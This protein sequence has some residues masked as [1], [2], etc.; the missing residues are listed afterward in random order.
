MKTEQGKTESV[1][2]T[3]QPKPAKLIKKEKT[4]RENLTQLKLSKGRN[5][6][7]SQ[8]TTTLTEPCLDSRLQVVDKVDLPAGSSM[9]GVIY[10]DQANHE[11]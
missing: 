7:P 6:R 3:V 4:L 8:V 9:V 2:T 5:Q 1:K 11:L 10:N